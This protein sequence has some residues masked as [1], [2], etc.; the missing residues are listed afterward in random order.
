KEPSILIPLMKVIHF[1]WRGFVADSFASL[2]LSFISIIHI[3]P[4]FS[5]NIIAC[6]FLHIRQRM[7]IHHLLIMD[8]IL[9]D[10]ICDD[11][12]QNRWITGFSQDIPIMF[13][14]IIFVFHG[15]QP[16]SS[17]LMV[18]SPLCGFIYKLS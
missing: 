5:V 7:V 2:Y 16:P 8:G 18:G 4:L 12:I 11:V 1:L 15:F 13:L 6:N 10:I 9:F 3:F 17:Y 14:V